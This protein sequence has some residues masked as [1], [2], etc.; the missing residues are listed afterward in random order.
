MTFQT[1]GLFLSSSWTYWVKWKLLSC[2]WLSV[3]S[4]D[5]SLPGSSVHGILQ[6]RI[7]ERIAIPFCRSS[8]EPRDQTQASRTA[9]GFFTVWATRGA[10]SFY[11]SCLF[12]GII[13]FWAIIP[14]ISPSFSSSCS[15]TMFSEKSSLTTHPTALLCTPSSALSHHPLFLSWC[16]CVCWVTSVM[17]NSLRPYGL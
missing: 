6:S 15:S 3:D 12:T 8:S 16:V 1:S 11:T 17:S 14:L 5:C 2:V 9:G 7:L 13:I 4:M 10:P